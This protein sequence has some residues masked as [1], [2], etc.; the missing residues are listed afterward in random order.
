MNSCPEC[1][2]PLNDNENKCPECG[3]PLLNNEP[4]N[5]NSSNSSALYDDW[6]Y[7]QY[8][9]G[10]F[11]QWYFKCEKNNQAD[12]YDS[13]NDVLLLFNLAFRAL[14][15]I[16]WPCALIFLFTLGCVM[17][18]QQQIGMEINALIFAIMGIIFGVMVFFAILIPNAIRKYWVPFHRTWRRINKRYW[19]SMHKAIN[20]NTL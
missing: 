17:A 13:L 6:D 8:R 3:Y 9:K 4:N 18:T 2:Y 20:T 16:I 11:K 14:W 10:L 19:I 5:S 1:G 7:E 12:S 15:S